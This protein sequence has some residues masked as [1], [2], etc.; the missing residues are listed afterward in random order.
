MADETSTTDTTATAATVTTDSAP[1]TPPAASAASTPKMFT[2]E[3]LNRTAAQARE[4]GRRSASKQTPPKAAETPKSTTPVV[5]SETPLLADVER[6]V[7]ARVA[8]ESSLVTF[9]VTNGIDASKQSVIRR[10]YAAAKPSD[11]S[12]WLDSDVAPL[13]GKP[14]APPVIQPAT[15]TP[16]TPETPRASP[17]AAP[18]APLAN[19]LPTAN[20]LPDLFA[21]TTAQ[22][23]ALGPAKVREALEAAW[24]IG[25]QM[26]GA[27]ERRR[28]P[29]RT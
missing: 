29:Q 8:A 11:V 13:L 10:Q 5:S 21:M 18:S 23:Q 4:E 19:A 28:G 16:A 6:I 12:A 27:P 15:T 26:S 9:F 25:N 20:G 14:P 22:H 24:K 17:A 3:D 1:A 2:Q 7:E